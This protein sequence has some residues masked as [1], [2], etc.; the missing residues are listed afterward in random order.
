MGS[1]SQPPYRLAENLRKDNIGHF[2]RNREPSAHNSLNQRMDTYAGEETNSE[3]ILGLFETMSKLNTDTQHNFA[4]TKFSSQAPDR[5]AT[6]KQATSEMEVGPSE[7]PAVEKGEFER[8][9]E[10]LEAR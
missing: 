8:Y 2:Q 5:Y 9:T 4:V 7:Q 1:P 3:G 10:E 6:S